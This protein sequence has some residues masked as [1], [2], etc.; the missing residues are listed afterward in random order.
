MLSK[1]GWESRVRPEPVPLRS[2]LVH[3]KTVL[4]I[5]ANAGKSGCRNQAVKYP[6]GQDRLV[7]LVLVVAVV[8]TEYFWYVFFLVKPLKCKVCVWSC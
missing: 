8:I 6:I 5:K 3:L 1:P 7:G 4:V 2:P